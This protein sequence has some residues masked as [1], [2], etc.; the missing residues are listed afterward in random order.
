MSVDFT[1]QCI[2]CKT[3][4]VPMQPGQESLTC[5]ACGRVMTAYE[6]G[7]QEVRA[8]IRWVRMIDAIRVYRRTTGADLGTAKDAV[9][10]MWHS[11][12]I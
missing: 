3:E 12:D 5:Q 9:T 11:G 7:M 2:A 4:L 8:Y 6:A 10:E 1:I